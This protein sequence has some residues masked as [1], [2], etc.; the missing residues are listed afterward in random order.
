[1]YGDI[2]TARD[3]VPQ[4]PR[5]PKKEPSKTLLIILAVIVVIAFLCAG[6]YDLEAI[7]AGI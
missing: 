7:K 1:M 6:H 2:K 5:P 3:R 4:P